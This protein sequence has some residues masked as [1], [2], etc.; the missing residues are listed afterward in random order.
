MPRIFFALWPTDEVRQN[1]VKLF[2]QSP[3]YQLPGRILPDSNLHLT[4]HFVGNVSVEKMQCLHNQAKHV[5][6]EPFNIKLNHYGY[7]QRPKIIWMGLEKVDTNL[8]SLHTNLASNL[9][10]CGYNAEQRAFNPHLSLIRKVPQPDGLERFTAIYWQVNEFVLV[11]SVST[12][13]GV[14]YKVIQHYP[15]Q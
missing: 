11:E 4:L 1:I 3:Y 7:F 5:I 6:A 10:P 12:E 13:A 8:L 15:L 2:K 14:Q 9:K